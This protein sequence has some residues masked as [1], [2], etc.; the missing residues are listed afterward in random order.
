MYLGR[1][2]ESDATCP[3]AELRVMDNR[4]HTGAAVYSYFGEKEI[5]YLSQ[6]VVLC[7]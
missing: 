4:V 6:A 2:L 1:M 5:G 7:A 3:N